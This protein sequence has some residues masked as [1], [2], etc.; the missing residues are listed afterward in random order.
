MYLLGGCVWW[1]LSLDCWCERL[2]S[3]SFHYVT[4]MNVISFFGS[5]VHFRVGLK[6]MQIAAMLSDTFSNPPV[7]FFSVQM[8]YGTIVR[9]VEVGVWNCQMHSL[10]NIKS[11]T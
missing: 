10:C 8:S 9:P 6:N 11:V 5:A 7:L 4:L 2:F 1:A 3:F